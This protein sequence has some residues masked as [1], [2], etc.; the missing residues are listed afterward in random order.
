MGPSISPFNSIK[1]SLT[2]FAILW[3]VAHKFRIAMS[4]LWTGALSLYNV[5]L[6]FSFKKKKEKYNKVNKDGYF[7]VVGFGLSFLFSFKDKYV[8]FCNKEGKNNNKD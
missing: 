8:I 7:Q 2:Y 1:F 4:S 6:C 5:L 3:S